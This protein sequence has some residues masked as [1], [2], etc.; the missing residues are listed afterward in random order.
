[1]TDES[2]LK[3]VYLYIEGMHCER[4][5]QNVRQSLSRIDGIDTFDVEVGQARVSYLP[6]IVGQEELRQAVESAG[7]SASYKAPRRNPWQR[8]LNRMIRNN[9]SMFG[10]KKPDCCTII[11]DQEERTYH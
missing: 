9:E 10:G 11:R 2:G 4:C 1:M 7:Y 6:Q 5:V 3:R 8:F